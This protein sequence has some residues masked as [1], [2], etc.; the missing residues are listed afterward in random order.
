M[1][2]TERLLSGN[3]KTKSAGFVTLSKQTI[4]PGKQKHRFQSDKHTTKKE[5]M[6]VDKNSRSS[7]VLFLH[8]TQQLMAIYYPLFEY[9]TILLL[10]FWLKMYV[11][12]AINVTKVMR[13]T[14]I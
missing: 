2:C 14:R 9:R 4:E 3:H 6:I 13:I 10:L 7:L 11:L 12:L 1:V 5:T 8:I